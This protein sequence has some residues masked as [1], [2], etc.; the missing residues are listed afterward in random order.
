[1]KIALMIF[2]ALASTGCAHL[3]MP[4]YTQREFVL[5]CYDPWLA[6]CS[7]KDDLDKALAAA[8]DGRAELLEGFH[9]T[10]A[11]GTSTTVN[12]NTGTVTVSDNSR[13]DQCHKYSCSGKVSGF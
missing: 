8:C 6:G 4:E 9:R 13:T 12:P 5:C 2:A 1:M 10:I 3:Y 11:G 7:K